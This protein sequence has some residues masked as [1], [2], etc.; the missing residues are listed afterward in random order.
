MFKLFVN[1]LLIVVK[2]AEWCRKNTVFLNN[3]WKVIYNKVILYVGKTFN[4][5]I[6]RKKL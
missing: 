2:V 3:V 6:K 1:I 5:A 4:I